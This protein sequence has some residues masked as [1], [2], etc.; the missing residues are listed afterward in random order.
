M[1]ELQVDIF[2]NEIPIDQIPQQK[3]IV[4]AKKYKTMQ[5]LHGTS[6][7]KTCKTCKH[8]VAYRHNFKTYYKCDLWI[9]SSSKATD[10]RLK[11]TAC[12]K[13]EEEQK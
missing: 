3:Q 8:C 1:S 13:Y 2:G 10:I 11:N 5:Q 9:V 7:G 6:E 4:G 12:K